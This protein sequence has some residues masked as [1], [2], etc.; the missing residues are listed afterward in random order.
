MAKLRRF[1]KKDY[2]HIVDEPSKV[3]H[4]LITVLKSKYGINVYNDPAWKGSE[5]WG[6]IL[7]DMK[8]NT[9]DLEEVSEMFNK[10]E[11]FGIGNGN[12][13]SGPQ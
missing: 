4:G 11:D 6:I 1:S 9:K 7:T 2:A 12:R 10:D 5:Q 13:T 8:L 3:I